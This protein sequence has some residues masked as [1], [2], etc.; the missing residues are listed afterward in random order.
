MKVAFTGASSTGKTTLANTL[1]KDPWIKSYLPLFI[2][3]DARSMLTS[4]G[5]QSMD[6]MPISDRRVFQVDYLSKKLAL[7]EGQDNYLTDRSFL[8]LAAYWIERDAAGLK[9][10]NAD[11]YVDRCRHEIGRYDIHFF[12]PYGCIPFKSDGYRSDNISFH[13]RIDSRI[14]NLITEW[15]V[16]VV[17]LDA[18]GLT[19]RREIVLECLKDLSS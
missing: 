18:V 13:A 19:K 7:E 2:T 1:R 16:K 14:Q 12:F 11:A 8:D 10:S 4:R 9:L 15:N 3:V 5:F 17:R 6:Q